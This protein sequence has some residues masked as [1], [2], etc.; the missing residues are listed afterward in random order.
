MSTTPNV[1]QD[2][3][4]GPAIDRRAKALW[5]RLDPKALSRCHHDPRRIAALVSRRTQLTVEEIRGM[6]V[7]PIVTEDEI[8]TW[9][10]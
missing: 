10:G 7:I 1:E 6:L 4:W 3:T 2:G 5:P 9:F 8:A